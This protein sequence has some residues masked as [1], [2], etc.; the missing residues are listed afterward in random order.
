[1]ESEILSGLSGKEEWWESIKE[2]GTVEDKNECCKQS[3]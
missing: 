2:E 1:M 3:L